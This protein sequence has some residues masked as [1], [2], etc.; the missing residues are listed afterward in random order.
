MISDCVPQCGKHD[1][2][3]QYEREGKEQLVRNSK[4]SL[5]VSKAKYE[6]QRSIEALN[7]AFE[8]GLSNMLVMDFGMGYLLRCT[9]DAI[10]AHFMIK[11]GIS[12][13]YKDR[14]FFF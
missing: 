3:F 12:R 10:E 7:F 5:L 11:Q 6:P 4:R 2:G 9:T 13:H 1:R 8:S 14:Y